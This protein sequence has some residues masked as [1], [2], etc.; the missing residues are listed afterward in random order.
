[1]H[2]SR[3]ELCQIHDALVE[4]IHTSEEDLYRWAEDL[5]PTD[6]AEEEEYIQ[7]LRALK[8]KVSDLLCDNSDNPMNY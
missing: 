2:F 6:A 8:G 5:P 7:D 4:L 1:M 3:D